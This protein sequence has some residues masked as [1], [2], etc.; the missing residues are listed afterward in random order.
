M[1]NNTHPAIFWAYPLTPAGLGAVILLLVAEVGISS[2]TAAAVL[3]AAGIA[4]GLLLAKRHAATLQGALSEQKQ[5]LHKQ[6]Q[7]EVESFLGGLNSI[8]NEITSL[9]V[10][11]IETGRS[12]TEQAMVE[13]TVRFSGI[14]DQLDKTV[15]ASSLSAGTADDNRGLSAIFSKSETQLQ[16]V[17][18]SMLEVVGRS[19]R[20]LGEVSNMVPFIDKLKAM[21]A[22]VAEIASQ[23]NLLALNAAIEAARAGEAGR[24]FAVV[25]D[26]VRKLSNSS[27]EMGKEIAEMVKVI[28]L[29]ISTAFE[30]AKKSAE[31]DVALKANA[32]AAIN[33]V[34]SDFKSVTKDLSDAAGVLRTSSEGIKIEVAESLVQLQFQD[35]VSQIL[36]HVRDNISAFPAYLQQSEQQFREQGQLQAIDWSDLLHKLESSYATTEEHSNHS[37]K[38]LA[39]ADDEITFF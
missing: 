2:L 16:S 20:L 33:G 24:G 26:E 12:Q 32:D 31:Q 19:D 17:I 4:S 39:A 1:D 29:S 3:V 28:S 6:H 7:A 27:G 22:S 36:S 37:G 38:K 11:Q 30:N 25:A 18:K 10:K 13:L 5:S 23:T 14:V 15:K 35:R 9:W 34:L 21:A 8:E